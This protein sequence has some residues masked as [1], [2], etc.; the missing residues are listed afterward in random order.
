MFVAT[1]KHSCPI[2]FPI[3]VVS[4]A[5]MISTIMSSFNHTPILTNNILGIHNNYTISIPGVSSYSCNLATRKHFGIQMDNL[6]ETTIKCTI[7]YTNKIY[8]NNQI[9]PEF[10]H[11]TL[12]S[13]FGGLEAKTHILPKPVA[14]FSR[15]FPLPRL[16]RTATI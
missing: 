13:F 6:I 2:E 5:D 3:Y 10:N 11:H 8:R 4:R 15:T 14:T 16:L 12:N 1:I 7:I 9:C